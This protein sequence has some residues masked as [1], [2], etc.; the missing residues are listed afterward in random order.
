[1]QEWRRLQR[2]LWNVLGPNL[3]VTTCFTACGKNSNSFTACGKL[4]NVFVDVQ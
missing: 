1:M 4:V 3:P 2:V